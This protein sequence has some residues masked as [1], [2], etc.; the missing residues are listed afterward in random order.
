MAK[1]MFW[2]HRF[3]SLKTAKIMTKILR[4]KPYVK[5]SVQD[6]FCILDC[7]DLGSDPVGYICEWLVDQKRFMGKYHHSSGTSIAF[8]K[9]QDRLQLPCC[10][11]GFFDLWL[12]PDEMQI[13]QYWKIRFQNLMAGMP[14]HQAD[15]DAHEKS[16]H[17][18][19]LNNEQKRQRYDDY[20]RDLCEVFGKTVVE[21]EH[22]LDPFFPC[23]KTMPKKVLSKRKMT[24]EQRKM[25]AKR[26]VQLMTDLIARLQFMSPKSRKRFLNDNFLDELRLRSI[27][28]A[29]GISW[30]VENI[31]EIPGYTDI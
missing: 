22:I 8:Q 21:A 23:W 25:A 19:E 31:G 24:E 20:R 14:M 12:F 7:H 3:D 1:I 18:V 5:V 11:F 30:V 9:K 26:E 2:I 16:G 15:M 27:I 13:F 17:H 6:G 29:N 10:R 4:R 28:K